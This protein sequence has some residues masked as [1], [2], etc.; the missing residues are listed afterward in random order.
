MFHMAKSFAY[1]RFCKNLTQWKMQLQCGIIYKF[2]YL[3]NAFQ[4]LHFSYMLPHVKSK[5]QM[6]FAFISHTAKCLHHP[7]FFISFHTCKMIQKC[8]IP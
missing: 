2:F 1:A 6:Y 7:L 3:K 4:S 8:Q 5:E